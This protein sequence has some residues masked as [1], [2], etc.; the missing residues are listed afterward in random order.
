M[1]GDDFEPAKKT[2][3][4]RFVGLKNQVD[5]LRL[6]SSRL[7]ENEVTALVGVGLRRRVEGKNQRQ[8]WARMDMDSTKGK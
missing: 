4:M 7:V 3:A 5:L 1:S 6:M 8:G 2:V